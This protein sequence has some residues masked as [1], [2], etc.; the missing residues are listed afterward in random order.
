MKASGL[1]SV[2]NALCVYVCERE[3][4]LALVLIMHY[5]CTL[6][7]LSDIINV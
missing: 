2:S 7:G 4:A 5:I 1:F 3:N 6:N